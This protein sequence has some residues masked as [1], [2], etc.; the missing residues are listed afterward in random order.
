MR[1][2]W[3]LVTTQKLELLLEVWQISF[4]EWSFCI[5]SVMLRDF[6]LRIVRKKLLCACCLC[7]DVVPCILTNTVGESASRGLQHWASAQ[8]HVPRILYGGQSAIH[9]CT[10]HSSI[11]NSTQNRI[12][13]RAHLELVRRTVCPSGPDG[14]Q[15]LY[16]YRLAGLCIAC[17]LHNSYKTEQ[18]LSSLSLIH[19]HKFSYALVE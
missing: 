17:I 3:F 10:V 12:V 2:S 6:V 1:C 15:V 7:T 14:P 9:N 13:S 11:P 4:E 18:V 8:K 19:H 16:R 5:E